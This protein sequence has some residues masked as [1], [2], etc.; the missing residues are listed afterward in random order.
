MSIMS[1]AAWG[2]WICLAL[3]FTIDPTFFLI[4][5]ALFLVAATIWTVTA[6]QVGTVNWA[7][8]IT[9]WALP[10]VLFS[11]FGFAFMY[12]PAIEGSTARDQ[13]LRH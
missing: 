5:A 4:G 7:T 10:I 8:I 13:A 12:M 11:F 2:T 6:V 9:V 1:M 3:G